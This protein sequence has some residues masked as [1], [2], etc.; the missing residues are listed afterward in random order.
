L[1]LQRTEGDRLSQEAET[2]LIYLESERN[3]LLKEQE[4]WWR[5]KSR[6]IWVKS[7]DQNNKFFHQF[8][9]QRR[10]SKFIWEIADSAGTLLNNQKDIAAESLKYFKNFFM[11]P[12]EVITEDQIRV[13]KN[14]PKMVERREAKIYISLL[15]WQNWKLS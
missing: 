1:I 6:A 9:T 13:V 3:K 2:K 4:E 15:L 12:P 14:Y 10:N 11:S 8:A 5:S 7:G